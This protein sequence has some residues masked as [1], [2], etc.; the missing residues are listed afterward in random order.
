MKLSLTK[1]VDCAAWCNCW[2]SVSESFSAADGL[3]RDFL[4]SDTNSELSFLS[5]TFSS[6]STEVTE[7]S[8]WLGDGL[9][10]TIF[11]FFNTGPCFELPPFRIARRPLLRT[12][13]LA[14]CD[15]V[16]WRSA[17]AHLSNDKRYLQTSADKY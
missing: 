17:V 11:F 1:S 15:K 9:D 10:L 8:V 5:I 7:S 16:C 13:A 6:S 3:V 14:E 4:S 2:L 12:P